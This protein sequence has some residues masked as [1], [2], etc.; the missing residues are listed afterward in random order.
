VGFSVN[1]GALAGLPQ[2]LDRRWASLEAGRRYLSGHATVGADQQ[3]VL[4]ACLGQHTHNVATI[5][6]YLAAAAEQHV[7]PFSVAIGRAVTYYARTDAAAAARLDNTSPGTADARERNSRPDRPADPAP[8]PDLFADRHDPGSRYLQPEDYRGEYRLDLTPMDWL[9]PTTTYRDL[10][11]TVTSIA[12]SVGLLDHAVDPVEE[13]CTPLTGDWTAFAQCADVIANVGAELADDAAGIDAGAAALTRVWTGNAADTCQA[14]LFR[15]A[16]ELGRAPAPLARLAQ[17]YRIAAERIRSLN[18]A[19]RAAITVLL[20]ESID[21]ALD[22]ATEGVAEVYV[23]PSLIGA[24]KRLV[25][26]VWKARGLIRDAW[27]VAHAFIEGSQIDLGDLGLIPA[28]GPLPVPATTPPALP[29]LLGRP[30]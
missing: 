19:M 18:E 24:L 4:N 2:L 10:V 9:S 11:W 6:G 22:A 13:F 20:D 7:G 1:A 28:A 23:A 5:D 8:P 30:R 17:R 29:A 16:L 21:L 25:Q 12:V 26:A 14:A 27:E 15:L 3:G